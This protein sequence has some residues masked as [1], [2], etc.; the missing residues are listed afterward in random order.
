MKTSKKP[1]YHLAIQKILKL[2]WDYG[3]ISRVDL[4]KISG[5]SKSTI[6]KNC[7][8]MINQSLIKEEIILKDGVASKRTNLV[9]HKDYGIIAGVEMDADHCNVGIC[10]FLG[11]LMSSEHHP[12]DYSSGPEIILDKI[13]SSINNQIQKLQ[14]GP[15][16]GIGI[17]L[18]SPVDFER[19]VA[20]HPSFMPGWHNYP[21]KKYLQAKMGCDVYVD[22]EVHTMALGEN[23]LSEDLK[24]SNL[25]FVKGGYGIGSGILI[26]G[27][28]FRGSTGL[29]GNL[30]HITIDN[31]NSLCQCGKKGCLE[32]VVGTTALIETA[33]QK[34]K[35]IPDSLLAEKM[36]TN[37]TITMD[38]ILQA[39]EAE[40]TLAMELIKEAG[41]ILGRTIG[42][43]VMFLDPDSVIIGGD[44]ADFGSLLIS[45]IYQGILEESSQWLS[46]D[47]IVRKSLNPKE[48]GMIG[49]SILCI[50]QLIQY[51]LLS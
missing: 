48:V 26:D 50:S 29:G 16:R 23:F 33:K 20:V 40:D 17:G 1:I 7:D 39:F 8:V 42:K 6:T 35:D 25:L 44:L 13:T 15:L 31:N 47:F 22:N 5:Y 2:I 4:G 32:S 41:K 27:T 21:T 18:P 12:I 38:D 14:K 45:H 51:K 34:L 37:G 9:I 46:R 19:G 24:S 10:D 49:A 28:I 3:P 30:G 43:M 36:K 11:N